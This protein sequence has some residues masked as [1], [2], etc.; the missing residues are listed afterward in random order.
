MEKILIVD[1]DPGTT[2]LLEIMLSKEGY[3]IVTVNDSY[4]ALSAALS[5]NPKLVLLDIKMPTT[6]GFEVCKSLRSTP[7]FTHV[8]IVFLTSISD[9]GQ[10]T[11]AFGL[12][13]SDYII[14]PIH[15]KELT[16]R[17]KALIGNGR[18]GN[19]N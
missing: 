8:P 12:G 2:K 7:Q 5:H 16:L 10:K 15:P 1:D 17:I 18:N 11:V 6:D 4:Q 9:V 3:E 14:K 13:A 19:H